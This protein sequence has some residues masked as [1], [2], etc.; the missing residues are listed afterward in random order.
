MSQQPSFSKIGNLIRTIANYGAYT[1][2]LGIIIGIASFFSAFAGIA[3][4]IGG[5]VLIIVLVIIAF[6]RVLVLTKDVMNEFES[7]G[8]SRNITQ[9]KMFSRYLFNSI[10]VALICFFWIIICTLIMFTPLF[11]YA[12]YSSTYY[13]TS[14]A[15]EITLTIV[16]LVVGFSFMP[17]AYKSWKL[18]DDYFV[19]LHDPWSRDIGLI[20]TKKVLDSL[21]TGFFA[22]FIGFGGFAGYTYPLAIVAPIIVLFTLIAGIIYIQ[23]L[24]RIGTAFTRIP[25]TSA[26]ATATT[27][28]QVNTRPTTVPTGGGTTPPS[29][30]RYQPS[31]VYYSQ[32][33]QAQQAA[34]SAPVSRASPSP[35]LDQSNPLTRQI[36]ERNQAFQQIIDTD[37]HG[38][39]TRTTPARQPD[40]STGATGTLTPSVQP[41]HADSAQSSQSSRARCKYCLAD[42]PGTGLAKCPSCGAAI[43]EFS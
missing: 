35:S 7:M 24:Y 23:G 2:G 20:G 43:L 39:P 4:T 3:V 6:F 32:G 11:F 14:Q 34:V 22:L 21:K 36:L 15:G 25:S 18:I 9:F 8:N 29:I 5:I 1:V 10:A 38:Q 27:P 41:L 31:Q 37:A 30:L 42:L 13:L 12:M 28:T 19:M 17:H 16:G 40:A 26:F 33:M